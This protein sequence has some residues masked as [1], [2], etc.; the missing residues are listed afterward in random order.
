MDHRWM[1]PMGKDPVW[2]DLAWE[3]PRTIR[4][5]QITFDTGFQRE[6]TLT[7]S[8][9]I[10]R[11]IIR[12]AQPETVRDYTLYYR[13]AAGG[14]LVELVK[15][16]GNHQRLNRHRFPAVEAQALRLHVRATNGDKLVRVFEVRCYA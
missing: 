8:D 5:V 14:P 2:L 12:A 9:A 11:G 4:H 3:K 7:A 1:A 15:V 13:K 6:L 10:S 16:D